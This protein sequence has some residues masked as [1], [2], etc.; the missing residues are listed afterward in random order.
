MGIDAGIRNLDEPPL[1]TQPL[2]RVDSPSGQ[3]LPTPAT[4]ETLTDLPNGTVNPN[5]PSSGSVGD[6]NGL[7]MPTGW[8]M[9][10]QEAR[11][12]TVIISTTSA[13]STSANEPTSIP[14]SLTVVFLDSDED[15]A[16]SSIFANN[17]VTSSLSAHSSDVYYADK[18]YDIAFAAFIE[19]EDSQT[20]GVEA[21]PS[22]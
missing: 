6:S 5:E 2:T 1:S 11:A 18:K 17:S 21:G 22:T 3:L 7:V 10:N 9:V 15:T 8:T 12:D 19:A 16:N 13:I 20:V 14:S 4:S